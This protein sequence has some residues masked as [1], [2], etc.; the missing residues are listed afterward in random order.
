MDVPET[1]PPS[2]AR[3]GGRLLP[4][5]ATAALALSLLTLA[6][7]RGGESA[8]TE[9]DLAARSGMALPVAGGAAPAQPAAA[10]STSVTIMGYE[11]SP[12]ALKVAAGDTV[13]WTNHDKAAHNVVISSGPEKFT[14]PTLQQ[15]Q[16]YSFTFTKAGNY[17]YYCSLHPDMKASVAVE[18]SA[19]TSTTAPPSTTAPTTTTA[20]TSPTHTMPPTSPSPGGPC[21]SKDSLAAFMAHVK[22][23][24]LERS[25]LLQVTDILDIDQ[26][27]LT[28]TVWL[29]QV[30]APVFDGTGDQAVRD[31]L[32]P[33]MAHLK[34]AHLERSPL[35]QVQDILAIDQYVKTHTVWLET[36]VAPLA[37]Q[38]T[39]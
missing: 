3:G 33:V 26:Y 25:P 28:H 15:G 1:R 22:S 2:R 35:E 23:A 36:V 31:T 11:Y 19:P 12:A 10:S 29:E 20:P 24:H 39:C 8:P 30:L 21:M 16:S 9:V 32:A 17:S 37:S 14:T 6:S 27:V 34:A 5:V 4:V 18:G 38:L 7:L 13:T